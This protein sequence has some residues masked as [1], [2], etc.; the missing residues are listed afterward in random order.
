ML[1]GQG[2][3]LGRRCA[4]AQAA[5]Q[6]DLPRHADA[7]HGNVSI[8]KCLPL[9]RVVSRALMK[10]A[11]DGAD[12]GHQPGTTDRGACTRRAHTFGGDLDVAILARGAANQ[13]RQRRIVVALPPS[14]LGV[15]FDGGVSRG[16]PSGRLDGGLKNG[17]SAPRQGERD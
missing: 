5:G 11:T 2:V 14:D 13:V 6:I 9:D 7:A 8:G 16:E 17:S 3:R 10:S 4:G 15:G 1:D 12:A